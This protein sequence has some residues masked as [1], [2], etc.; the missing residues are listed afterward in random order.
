M[1]KL[2]IWD[3]MDELERVRYGIEESMAIL[4]LVTET[5]EEELSSSKMCRDRIDMYTYP[6]WAVRGNLSKASEQL[7]A[8]VEAVCQIGKAVKKG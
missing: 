2:N 3:T 5:L 1:E 4:Q 7:G 6:L 8:S